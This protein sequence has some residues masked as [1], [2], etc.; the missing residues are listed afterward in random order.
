MFTFVSSRA[1]AS[2]FIYFLPNVAQASVLNGPYV[3]RSGVGRHMTRAVHR[4]PA[5]ASAASLVALAHGRGDRVFLG[6]A[7]VNYEEWALGEKVGRCAP[8]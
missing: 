8:L 7:D 3:R 1:A 5:H 4:L 2:F 6:P